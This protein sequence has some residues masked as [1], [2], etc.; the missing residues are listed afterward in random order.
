MTTVVVAV[1]AY[2]TGVFLA[3]AL[4]MWRGLRFD[5]HVDQALTVA[6]PKG[7][8]FCL[9]CPNHPRVDD[10][11]THSRLVHRDRA[12]GPDDDADFL[13]GLS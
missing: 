4:W 13:A 2:F 7:L 11:L 8:I 6:R 5:R 9:A 3:A 10:P 1:A 12:L